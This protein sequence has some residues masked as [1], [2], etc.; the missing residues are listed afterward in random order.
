MTAPD[1]DHRPPRPMRS[2]LEAATLGELLEQARERLDAADP[3]AA[4]GHVMR[5][6]AMAP[7]HHEVL[8]ML[9]GLAATAG[10]GATDLVP[11]RSEWDAQGAATR[12]W[13]L[14]STGHIS[15]GMALLLDVVSS[16]VSRPWGRWLEVWSKRLGADLTV[17]G[18][19]L[20]RACR[21]LVATV[22]TS[23][24]GAAISSAD[25]ACRE[26]TAVVAHFLAT[27]PADARLLTMGSAVARR[28]GQ[29]ELAAKWAF[30]AQRLEAG[31][32]R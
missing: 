16:D 15:Q 23:P 22:E 18:A 17:S 27:A 32:Q 4:L 3:A 30:D 2:D 19:A 13:L 5:A 25:L 20:V 12:S 29:A 28:A 8:S 31:P 26:V 24:T 10:D 9:D 11:E 21:R 7:D 6:V 14:L 1:G